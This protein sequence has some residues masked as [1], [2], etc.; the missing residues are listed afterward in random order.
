MKIAHSVRE[1]IGRTPLLELTHYQADHALPATVLAKLECMESP[2]G[3]AK[4]RW[5]PA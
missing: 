4:D 1:L 5:L 2:P 3:S